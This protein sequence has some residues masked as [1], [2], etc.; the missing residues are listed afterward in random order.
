MVK[1]FK[2]IDKQP[3]LQKAH[4]FILENPTLSEETVP[5]DVLFVG[6]GPAGL[7]GAIKLAQLVKDDPDLQD[8]EI[9]VLEK[10]E[11]LGGHTLSGAVINPAP[12]KEL[13]PEV[14]EK[15]LPFKNKV[16]G[17]AVYMLTKNG[18][19][20][21][22]TP[23][24]M[25][26]HG[27]YSASLCEVVRWMGEK[28]EDLGI[29]VFT[30]FPADSLLVQDGKVIGTRTT[31][32]GL[33]RD[34]SPGP[35]HMEGTDVTAEV[36]VLT[37]G[38]RGPLAQSYLKWANLETAPQIFALGVK[39]VWKIKKPLNKVIHTLGWPLKK[40]TFGG[41]WL[42]P[43]GDDMVSIGL[44]AG[45]DYKESD[46]DVHYELQQLK[47]HPL[48]KDLL[49]GGELLQWGAKTIPEG[50]YHS[51][52]KS[53]S[54]NGVLLAGDCVGM[55]NVPA[56]KG[57]HYAMTSGIKSAETIF[58]SLKQ[59]EFDKSL[60]KYDEKLKASVIYKDL[61]KVRNMRQAFKCGFFVGG[62]KA[63]LMTLTGGRFPGGKPHRHEDAEE[64]KV[65]QNTP[66]GKIDLQKV[67]AVF[68]SANK[69]RDDLPNHLTVGEDISKEW[70][71]FYVNLCPAGVYEME[72]DKLV[73]KSPN[74]VDCKATDVLG[75]RWQPREGGS[76]P[77]YTIM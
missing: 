50:G 62:L 36:T 14:D 52:P 33:N 58:E 38:T 66:K 53:F 20:R 40:S 61:Y 11:S 17:E 5:M 21:I 24:T 55:V 77:S 64:T 71:E 43:M 72:D 12:L 15:D 47:K 4:S 27:N 26:N 63:A 73:V 42:Y 25:Q 1:T 22:P 56:L 39:E 44:V 6:A 31:P 7:A 30:S 9:G 65:F 60:K 23:P 34:G 3:D 69:T 41:S 19:I 18:K 76:G 10:S 13:F 2:P 48:F 68:Q 75:P 32:T 46:L 35:S 28:A 29:N 54:G 57:V 16:D 70:A 67:D 45:L 59:K 8:I 51:F 74:C 37:E 49:E